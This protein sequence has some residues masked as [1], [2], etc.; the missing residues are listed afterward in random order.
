M[1][2][3]QS[4]S[5][6]E[7]VPGKADEAAFWETPDIY[8]AY[9]RLTEDQVARLAEHGRRRSMAPNDVLIREGERCE[10]FFVVAAAACHDTRPEAESSASTL[11]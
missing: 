9:P 6:G 5:G 4:L 1:S 10:T 11:T 8:G 3:D 7:P 2:G